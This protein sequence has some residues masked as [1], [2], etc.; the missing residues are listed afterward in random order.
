MEEQKRT[1]LEATDRILKKLSANPSKL[2]FKVVGEN[3]AVHRSQG[4]PE[5]YLGERYFCYESIVLA[6]AEK[7]VNKKNF[8][9]ERGYFLPENDRSI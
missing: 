3:A 1:R 8:G 4:E 6:I 9:K 2:V 5:N 7:L